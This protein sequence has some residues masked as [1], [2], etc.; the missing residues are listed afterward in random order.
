MQTV[1]QL[2]QSPTGIML[3]SKRLLAR[4]CKRDCKNSDDL[5]SVEMKKQSIERYLKSAGRQFAIRRKVWPSRIR[6]RPKNFSRTTQTQFQ[7]TSTTNLW[8]NIEVLQQ[9]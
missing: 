1:E 7:V 6:L 9:L 2:Q 5:G 3:R 8:G 4:Q